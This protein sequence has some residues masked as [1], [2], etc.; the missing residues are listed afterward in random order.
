MEAGPDT[1]ENVLK[2]P[3]VLVFLNFDF[4]FAV[5]TYNFS[6]SVDKIISKENKDGKI[7]PIYFSFRTVNAA[8]RKYFVRKQEALAEVLR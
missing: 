6:V 7:H 2:S 5:E 3:L 4:P 1:L 8:E